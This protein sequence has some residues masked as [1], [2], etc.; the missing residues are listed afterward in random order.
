MSYW[1]TIRIE[2]PSNASRA[3]KSTPRGI[4]MSALANANAPF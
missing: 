2:T 4:T 3:A 1:R